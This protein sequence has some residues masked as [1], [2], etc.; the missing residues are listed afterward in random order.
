MPITI[1]DCYKCGKEPR[2]HVADHGI[3][4]MCGNVDCQRA[5]LGT[6][7]CW[8]SDVAIMR[9]NRDNSSQY[10]DP[11]GRK[12]YRSRDGGSTMVD[13]FEGAKL[14]VGTYIPEED[15]DEFGW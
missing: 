2:M 8:L 1:N 14:Q 9:W 4:I 5:G 12:P 6:E 15:T 11:A 10:K 13:F 3:N 7:P